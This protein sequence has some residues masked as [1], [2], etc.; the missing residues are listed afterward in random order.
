[1]FKPY[2][3]IIPLLLLL[4]FQCHSAGFLTKITESFEILEGV[5]PGLS[6]EGDVLAATTN[7]LLIGR[8]ASI[9]LIDLSSEDLEVVE[10]STTP[11]KSIHIRQGREMVFLANTED[12][13][14]FNNLARG[15]FRLSSPSTSIV[16]LSY[17]CIDPHT[18][19]TPT[20]H[21]DLSVSGRVALSTLRNS[22]GTLKIVSATDPIENLID[23][24]CSFSNVGEVAI[25]DSGQ[26]AAQM[27][28]GTSNRG[29][30]FFDN[31]VNR[32]DYLVVAEFSIGGQPQIDINNSGTVIFSINESF[33]AQIDGVE[34]RFRPGVYLAEATPISA[35]RQ[36]RM[37]ADNSG[38]FCFFGSVTINNQGN[39]AFTAQVRD[40]LLSACDS[41]SS[42]DGV[43]YGSDPVAHQVVRRGDANLESHQ[44]FDDVTLGYLNNSGQLS[45][46]TSYSEP[47]VAP[48]FV[49][50]AD[51]SDIIPSTLEG[52][53]LLRRLIT[54][55]TEVWQSVI[56]WVLR[57]F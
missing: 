44:F 43:F 3:K 12:T 32:R 22:F 6:D 4:S 38:D 10:G 9:S 48:L 52:R 51:V 55:I 2:T 19:D 50:R 25:N 13:S 34:T 37:V 18:P 42:M 53:S 1:M 56:Q 28:F 17:G 57:F 29:I 54:F 40:S 15:I 45:L 21:I 27:E 47:L 11:R 5:R 46:M 7:Q 30:Y 36:I 41:T 35:D 16:N 33:T 26:Y 8:G 14:C 39:L 31:P 24:P 20:H 49:W 23:C